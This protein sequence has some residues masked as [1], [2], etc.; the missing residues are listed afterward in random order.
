MTRYLLTPS[1]H[2]AYWYFANTD[3]KPIEE[4]MATLKKEPFEKSDAMLKG[5]KF[6]DDVLAYNKGELE[7]GDLKPEYCACVKQIGDIVQG[8]LWQERLSKEIEFDGMTFLLYGKS[9]V[10][11]RDWIYDI[12]FTG[13]YDIGKF[14]KKLQHPIYMYLSGLRKFDY[15]VTN[16]RD[17]YREAYFW[18]RDTEANMMAELKEM[19]GFIMSNDN[20]REAF[21]EHWKTKY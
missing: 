13:T 10:I 3:F 17:V 15:L 21:L 12:K 18:E 2:D 4:F 6:E 7:P 5:I 20:F 16:L 19:V 1:L 9:D 14:S 11:K 8:G